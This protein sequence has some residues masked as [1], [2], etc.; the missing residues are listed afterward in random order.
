M[1]TEIAECFSA[2]LTEGGGEVKV[3]MATYKFLRKGET[4]NILIPLKNRSGL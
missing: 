3:V 4:K 2:L 1:G